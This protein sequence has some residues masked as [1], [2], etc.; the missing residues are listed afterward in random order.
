MHFACLARLLNNHLEGDTSK[1][2]A[3]RVDLSWKAKGAFKPVETGP[4]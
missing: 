3:H 4:P 2:K 1:L